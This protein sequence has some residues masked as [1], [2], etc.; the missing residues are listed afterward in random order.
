MAARFAQRWLDCLHSDFAACSAE[1]PPSTP[2]STAASSVG[3][4]ATVAFQLPIYL[5]PINTTFIVQSTNGLFEVNTTQSPA[6]VCGLLKND[7]YAFVVTACNKHG[8]SAAS[9]ASN[10]IDI[11]GSLTLMHPFSFTWQCR[12]RR[13]R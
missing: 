1:G 13:L 12:F 9:A 11:T 5:P 2:L 3:D 8:C 4:C 7:S 6:L 10:S